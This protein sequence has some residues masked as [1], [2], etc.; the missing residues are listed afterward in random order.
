MARQWQDWAELVLGVWL[1][2]SP[3]VLGYSD[4]GAA[5]GNAYIIGAAIAIL[6]IAELSMPRRWEEWINLVLGVWLIIAPWVLGFSNVS[7]AVQN[8]VVVGIIM[9]VLPLWAMGQQPVYQRR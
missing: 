8:S 6:A 5:A 4:V 1:F 2:I 9:I 3:W 7:S